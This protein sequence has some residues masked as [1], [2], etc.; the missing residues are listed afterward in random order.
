MDNFFN[1][2]SI[3]PMSGTWLPYVLKEANEIAI[4]L[5]ATVYFTFNDKEYEVKPTNGGEDYEQGIKG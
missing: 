3:E 5:N 2:V 4:K 1:R